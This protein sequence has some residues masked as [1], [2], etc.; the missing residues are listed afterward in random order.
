M[1]LTF[2]LSGRSPSSK[3]STKFIQTVD[4]IGQ[5][6]YNI[7]EKL[8]GSEV[9]K[10]QR[11]SKCLTELGESHCDWWP[12][13]AADNKVTLSDLEA[14]GYIRKKGN[15][16]SSGNPA[17]EITEEGKE[18]VAKT[19]VYLRPSLKEILYKR[20]GT[21]R[22]LG[23]R[24]M[25]FD[26]NPGQQCYFYYRGNRVGCGAYNTNYADFIKE[27][28]D[29][30]IGLICSI[31]TPEY[32]LTTATLE[33]QKDRTGRT[34]KC[35]ILTDQEE[36]ILRKPFYVGGKHTRNETCAKTARYIISIIK[37]QGE[38]DR[39]LDKDRTGGIH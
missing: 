22:Y 4:L 8:G 25:V 30:K 17:Y 9:N 27:Y 21:V 37:R 24:I 34:I 38:M 33:Y 3:V 35:L 28:L 19:A 18:F 11:I 6:F 1:K 7:I 39:A 16:T 31:D 23:K 2:Y 36:G 5:P 29:S 14:K 20:V 15:K 32:P 10:K 13:I 12:N 26:D